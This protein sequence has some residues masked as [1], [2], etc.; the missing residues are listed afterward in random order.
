[1]KSKKIALRFAKEAGYDGV[2]YSGTYK[3]KEVFYPTFQGSGPH[4]V[5]A[6][7]IIFVEDGQARLSSAEE[8]FRYLDETLLKE[9][10][11]MSSPNRKEQCFR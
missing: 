10:V 11:S 1:M 3:G 4:Y 8:C 5:G 9:D 7:L 2:R 6:P